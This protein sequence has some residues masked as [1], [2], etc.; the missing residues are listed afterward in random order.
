[1]EFKDKDKF[2]SFDEY[3]E[4]N[5]KR[6]VDAAPA[7]LREERRNSGRL[8]TMG[9]WLLAA[10]PVVVMI[11]FLNSGLIHNEVLNLVVS[12]VIGFVVYTVDELIKP[13]VTGKRSVVDIDNDI[14]EYFRR[15][16]E[17]AE[18]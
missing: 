5:K 4:V 3:W 16:W 2:P 18:S 12:L 17:G 10:V 15:E 1:M 11:L 9:D 8:N 13:Y 14:K 7:E 6:L